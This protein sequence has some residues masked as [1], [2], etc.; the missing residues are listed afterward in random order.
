MRKFNVNH[1]KLMLDNTI[2]KSV[3]QLVTVRIAG[4]DELV[5]GVNMGISNRFS[6]R[7]NLLKN[8]NEVKEIPLTLIEGVVVKPEE[9]YVIW[10]LLNDLST[11]QIKEKIKEE[12]RKKLQPLKSTMEAAFQ[13][14]IERMENRKL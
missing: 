9:D 2:A 8:D 6:S 1:I 10:R 7:I 11:S 4:R 14:V 3:S 12:Q 13:N 5:E